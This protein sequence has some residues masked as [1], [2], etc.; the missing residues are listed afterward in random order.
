M[1]NTDARKL[2]TEAQQQIRNQAIRLK[3]SG[4][5]YREISEITGV[6][7]TTI[8]QWYKADEQGGAK[9]IRIKKRGRPKGSCRTLTPEQEKELQKAMRDRCPDQLKLPFNLWTRIAVQQFEVI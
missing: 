5:T 6:H 3:R 4:R 9:A 7:F 2:S 1:E 8:C